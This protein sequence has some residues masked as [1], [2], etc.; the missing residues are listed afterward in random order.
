MGPGVIH[1]GK[2]YTAQMVVIGAAGGM[3]A[4]GE[5]T[6]GLVAVILRA[7][8]MARRSVIIY[9]GGPGKL[10]IGNSDVSISNTPPL[11]PPSAGVPGGHV[12]LDKNS[13][14]VYIVADIV[15]T[16]VKFL[17]ELNDWPVH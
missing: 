15:D 17:E 3:V 8:G 2:L 1:Q 14:N 11:F 5:A 6:V 16:A 13:G 7:K 9:N 4:T 10:Y 12:T